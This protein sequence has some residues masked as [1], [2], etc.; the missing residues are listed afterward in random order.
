[1]YN[2]TSYGCIEISDRFANMAKNTLTVFH[3]SIILCA[4]LG[5]IAKSKV[6]VG[7]W[8]SV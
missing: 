4:I 1:M 5:K 7:V 3:L 6:R 2:K 8:G